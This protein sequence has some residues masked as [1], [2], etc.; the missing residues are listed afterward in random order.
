MERASDYYVTKTS[1][2][3]KER[4]GPI[5]FD[6]VFAQ[7]LQPELF[8]TQR[9]FQASLTVSK[10]GVHNSHFI[11]MV[12]HLN[13]SR[14]ENLELCF[15]SLDF[16]LV[17]PTLLQN[18][19]DCMTVNPA[20]LKMLA[21][22]RPLISRDLYRQFIRVLSKTNIAKFA[23]FFEEF[24]NYEKCHFTDINW[25]EFANLKELYYHRADMIEIEPDSLVFRFPP[26]LNLIDLS[27]LSF[28]HFKNADEVVAINKLFEVVNDPSNHIMELKLP[29]SRT[30][31]LVIKTI[32]RLS[33]DPN[34][35]LV[36][37]GLG[38]AARFA[39]ENTFILLLLDLL[40]NPSCRLKYPIGFRLGRIH[41]NLL[42]SNEMITLIKLFYL[43][44]SKW[45][46][47]ALVLL[48]L[49]LPSICKISYLSL[50][51][52]RELLTLLLPIEI[53]SNDL[54]N[55]PLIDSL[56]N[57]VQLQALMGH[58]I[59]VDNII[60]H[61]FRIAP[62]RSDTCYSKC[63]NHGTSQLTEAE[64]QTDNDSDDNDQISSSDDNSPN[65]EDDENS[66]GSVVSENS[67][68]SEENYSDFPDIVTGIFSNQEDDSDPEIIQDD[69]QT[70]LDDE[71]NEQL[72]TSNHS[73]DSENASNHEL[74][75]ESSNTADCSIANSSS[76]ENESDYNE[77]DNESNLSVA[78]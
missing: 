72:S 40:K 13:T 10:I 14:K 75:E 42:L 31:P 76:Q 17:Q 7:F 47:L 65:D 9:V 26:S 3:C 58:I 12:K 5:S 74:D 59:P 57:V 36:R 55:N 25:S 45:Y 34:C 27:G 28:M 60:D 73:S 46:D 32:F 70:E 71:S 24:D 49:Y 22:H 15:G 19:S 37:I 61:V 54:I 62:I 52:R 16:R 39:I 35:K 11:S 23:I 69:V 64:L 43:R 2:T 50:D 21:L 48:D 67:S 38:I 41:T 18:F 6:K 44:G 8:K 29:Q 30:S 20:R 68:S 33:C 66:L 63:T 78:F 1:V 53:S 56:N 51:L 4:L 77:S